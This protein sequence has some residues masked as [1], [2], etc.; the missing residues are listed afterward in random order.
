[1][2]W[3]PIPDE[4][5]PCIGR[6]E[7]EGLSYDGGVVQCLSVKVNVHVVLDDEPGD[8]KTLR[9][10]LAYHPPVCLYSIEV[11]IVLISSHFRTP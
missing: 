7:A 5:I 2:W 3:L 11:G 4:Q 6:Y 1:M 8:Y 10:G 9:Q